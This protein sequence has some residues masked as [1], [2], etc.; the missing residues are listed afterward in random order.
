MVIKK[1]ASSKQGMIVFLACSA[2]LLCIVAW[3]SYDELLNLWPTE[4]MIDALKVKRKKVQKELVNES[5]KNN[6]FEV[7]FS[8]LEKQDESFYLVDSEMRSDDFM[9]KKIEDLARSTGVVIKSLSDIRK[10]QIIKELY[11]LE[12]NLSVEGQT[13]NILSFLAGLERVSPKLYWVQCDLRSAG[14]RNKGGMTLNGALKLICKESQD[15]KQIV[16][17]PEK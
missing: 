17:A 14:A 2:L 1:I 15:L 10:N 7:E 8:K 13:K 3:V 5:Q 9:R 16:G 11:S 12:V 6:A 4:K